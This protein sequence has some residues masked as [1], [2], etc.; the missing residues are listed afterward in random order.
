M[1]PQADCDEVTVSDS[2]RCF[3]ENSACKSES[4][5]PGRSVFDRRLGSGRYDSTVAAAIEFDR[6]VLAEPAVADVEE[7]RTSDT[8]LTHCRRC[9]AN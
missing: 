6:F 8:G 1:T 5:R 3:V 7:Q 9:A 4:I 2:R